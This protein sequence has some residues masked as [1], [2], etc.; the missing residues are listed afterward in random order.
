MGEMKTSR[1]FAAWLA[2]GALVLSSAG[3]SDS[4]ERTE[5]RLSDLKGATMRISSTLGPWP[6]S[7]SDRRYASRV[8]VSFLGAPTNCFTLAPEVRATVD[9]VPLE[10][11][12]GEDD[13]CGEV[14]FR[15]WPREV[16]GLSK[17]E[18]GPD[19]VELTD[20]HDVFRAT[21]EGLTVDHRF[22]WL[23]ERS[24]PPPLSAGS[25]PPTFPN[26]TPPEPAPAGS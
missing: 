15:F 20:G 12:A 23:S 11:V 5:L 14:A 25:K 22:S 4:P 8:E 3:C 17:D 18:P 26:R 21:V 6:G 1:R 13:A 16:S 2:G 24:N 19:L 10:R 9:G 7:L